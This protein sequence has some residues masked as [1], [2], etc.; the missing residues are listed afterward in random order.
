MI[1]ARAAANALDRL[2]IGSLVA[3]GKVDADG[4]ASVYLL[5]HRMRGGEWL[6]ANLTTPGFAASTTVAT[7][8][9][10][11]VV[12]RVGEAGVPAMAEPVVLDPEKVAAWLHD[13]PGLDW[14]ATTPAELAS[15]LV[16]A[17]PSLT[18]TVGDGTS[19]GSGR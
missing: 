13:A 6:W 7:E 5:E 3:V 10:D 17:L 16:A 15:N 9:D 14:L 19:G 2:P 12:C 1:R 4:T 8:Y 18:V 11:I